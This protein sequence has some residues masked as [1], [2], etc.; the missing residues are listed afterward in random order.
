MTP[1]YRVTL[2][3]AV[4]IIKTIPGMG[5]ETIVGFVRPNFTHAWMVNEP[6]E[7]IQKWVEQKGGTVELLPEAVLA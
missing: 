1:R 7:K 3:R 6:L 4:F 2:P 5:A